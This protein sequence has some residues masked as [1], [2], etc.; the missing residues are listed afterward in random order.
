VTTFVLVLA[1]TLPDAALTPGATRFLSKD[2]ICSTRWGLDRRHVTAAMK[3]HV[4]RAYGINWTDHLSYEFDHLI[5]RELGGAD[6]ILNL[7]PQP[8]VEARVKDQRENALHRAVCAGQM[9][10]VAAQREMR[11]WGQP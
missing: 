5:P 7:W 9:T 1:L 6:N 4:A 11:F 10:L 3:R 2:V 8:L